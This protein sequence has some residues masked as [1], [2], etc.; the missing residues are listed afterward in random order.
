MAASDEQI[1]QWFDQK[2]RRMS[3]HYRT[4]VLNSGA[5]ISAF[6]DLYAAMNAQIEP[7]PI[8]FEDAR[9]DV[10]QAATP[11]AGLSFNSFAAAFYALF[12]ENW[13]VQEP[14]ANMTDQRK[15]ELVNVLRQNWG[16][17]NRLCV[18]LPEP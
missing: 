13:T 12:T 16:T 7:G 8:T 18:R 10:P 1:Q 6:D 9:I 14:I 17:I 11:Q 5:V 15:I 2:S 3:E 4:A